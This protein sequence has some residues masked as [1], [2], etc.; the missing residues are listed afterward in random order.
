MCKQLEQSNALVHKNGE[1]EM[2]IR[3][4]VAALDPQM[5]N[6]SIM[7]MRA[8]A[9]KCIIVAGGGNIE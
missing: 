7:D 4:E 6:R 9:H 5:I 1:L 3:R 2:N 8:K